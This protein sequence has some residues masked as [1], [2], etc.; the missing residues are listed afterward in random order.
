M[1]AF[2]ARLLNHDGGSHPD[3]RFLSWK[4]VT[5]QDKQ[6]SLPDGGIGTQFVNM[7]WDEIENAWRVGS[8]QSESLSSLL[9]CCNT[10]R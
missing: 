9:L 1:L 3:V 5:L 2:G 8:G 10:T 7:L 4:V 6:Y